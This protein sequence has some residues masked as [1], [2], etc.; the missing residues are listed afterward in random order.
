MFSSHIQ[1]PMQ[2]SIF[3]QMRT[4]ISL[5]PLNDS[6]ERRSV[7]SMWNYND[8]NVEDEWDADMSSNDIALGTEDPYNSLEINAFSA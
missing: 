5:T 2:L 8:Q 1:T 7:A 6:S 3:K 4:S